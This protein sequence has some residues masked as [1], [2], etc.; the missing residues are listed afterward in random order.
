MGALI[1]E[2]VNKKLDEIVTFCFLG[3][4]IS[5]RAM[6]VL[7]VKFVLPNTASI[8]HNKLAHLFPQLADV[9]SEFQ[10]SRNCLTVYGMTPLDDTDYLSPQSF[11]V[12]IL[13]YMQDLESL[14]FDTRDVAKEDR[15][16]AT[17]SFI[18][19]FIELLIP[20]TKQCLLLVDK[21]DAYAGD[22]MKFD[23]DIDKF[24][25]L[26]SLVDGEW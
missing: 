19:D 10:G 9:V 14:C 6:S 26:G 21:G 4:R 1:S 24:I 11:F 2:S 16:Y 23:H 20:V 13:E 22:W 3:N 5:D 18:D 25:V 12:K 8:L 7:D 17:L 15:D